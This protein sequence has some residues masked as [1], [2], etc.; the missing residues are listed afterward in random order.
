MWAI[1]SVSTVYNIWPGTALQYQAWIVLRK[2]DSKLYKAKANLN[3]DGTN[4]SNQD[5]SRRS[6]GGRMS[7][8]RSPVCFVTQWLLAAHGRR[9]INI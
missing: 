9:S 6:L 5:G 4:A 7:E 3:D 2:K 8:P 1:A